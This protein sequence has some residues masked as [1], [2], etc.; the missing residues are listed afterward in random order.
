MTPA[1]ELRRLR[2]NT[3]DLVLEE[4][5][6]DSKLKVILPKLGLLG[7]VFLALLVLIPLVSYLIAVITG[8]GSTVANIADFHRSTAFFLNSVTGSQ[9]KFLFP[10]PGDLLL[11]AVV[12]L[13]K[14]R[15]QVSLGIVI[16][17]GLMYVYGQF[18]VE[19]VAQ[20]FYEM[21]LKSP[22]GIAL[23]CLLSALNAAVIITIAFFPAAAAIVENC[24][25]KIIVPCNILLCWAQPIWILL[26]FLSFKKAVIVPKEIKAKTKSA[27]ASNRLWAQVHQ[28]EAKKRKG[29]KKK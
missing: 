22:V 15:W 21:S 2:F 23:E 7:L 25:W 16:A 11:A 6:S 3:V 8:K 10:G 13:Y 24:R 28:R 19:P 12:L 4:V 1:V 29:F 9:S 26:T 17:A 27:A 14:K 5:T 20:T 18:V